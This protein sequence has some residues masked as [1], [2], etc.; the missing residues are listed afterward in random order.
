MEQY[1]TVDEVARKLGVTRQAIYNWL[2]DGRLR[3]VKVGSLTR[4]REREVDDFLGVYHPR[5][6]KEV[7]H[8]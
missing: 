4:I 3:A 5:T 8:E 7:D 1:Y 2:K 6:A